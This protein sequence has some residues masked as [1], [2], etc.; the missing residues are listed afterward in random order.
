MWPQPS[1]ADLLLKPFVWWGGGGGG[2][3]GGA[4]W[5]AENELRARSCEPHTVCVIVVS[6]SALVHFLLNLLQ[7]RVSARDLY[8]LCARPDRQVPLLHHGRFNNLSSD[9]DHGR[10]HDSVSRLIQTP[11]R[12]SQ[13]PQPK[14]DSPLHP[15]TFAL[16]VRSCSAPSCRHVFEDCSN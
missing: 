13:T 8:D 16:S 14:S 7:T 9:W 2:T 10:V 1:H 11:I 4:V 15:V 12:I 5:A 3:W 6:F